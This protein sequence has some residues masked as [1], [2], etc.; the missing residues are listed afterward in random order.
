MPQTRTLGKLAGIAEDQWGFV[1]RRQA[2]GAGVSPA[3]L[4]RLSNDGVLER[5]AP[6]VYHLAGAPI[7]DH[8]PLRAAWLQLAPET[9][10]WQRRPE[11]GIVSHRSAAALYGL[12][13][14]PADVHEFILPTRRQ[15][16]RPDVRIHRGTLGE[17]EWIILRGL[18]V[19][20]PSRIAS[21]L[22]RDGEEP[23]AVAHVV[24]DAIRGVFDYPGTFADTLAPHATRFG[25]RR[26]DGVA[27]LRWLLD[28]VGDPETG[29]W[30]EEARA[31]STDIT[32]EHLRQAP[33]AAVPAR[34][35]IDGG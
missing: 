25:L 18:P 31:T 27:V 17:V 23:E 35:T 10:A 16:R 33:V 6:G 2:D 26:G 34:R 5:E 29:Q 22:L 24:T 30:M 20:R 9:P 8:A 11:Q 13:H 32:P 12:G 28:L 14:L 4:Q 19:T 15:V 3:T 1:T 7:P 21:D